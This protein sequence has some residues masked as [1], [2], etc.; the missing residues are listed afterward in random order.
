MGKKGLPGYIVILWTVFRCSTEIE[1]CTKEA[2]VAENV[3]IIAVFHYFRFGIAQSYLCL[4]TH[5]LITI[6]KDVNKVTKDLHTSNWYASF[7]ISNNYRWIEYVLQIQGR[8][9]S[10]LKWIMLSYQQA[11][12]YRA[13]WWYLLIIYTILAAHFQCIW[14]ILQWS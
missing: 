12:D 4:C 8:I 9:E 7:E 5:Y 10:H 1:K 3:K 6:H 13:N 11:T 2:K 14:I